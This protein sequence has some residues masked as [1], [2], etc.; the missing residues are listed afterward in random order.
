VANNTTVNFAPKGN[1]VGGVRRGTGVMVMANDGVLVEGNTI[2]DNPTSS[3]MVVSY[4]MPFTDKT[5]NPYPRNVT[6][7]ANRVERN[8]TDPQIEGREPLLA[9]FGGALPPVMWDGL[10]QDGTVALR[11]DPSMAGWT[12]GLPAQG[13][14]IVVANAQPGPLKVAA[15]VAGWTPKGV[16]APAA[17]EARL[18]P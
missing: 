14:G 17:L 16:G 12:L 10:S 11:V 5:Y 9:A 18:V 8:G 15:P 3:V 4:P 2:I 7:G 6:I 1:I 13:G